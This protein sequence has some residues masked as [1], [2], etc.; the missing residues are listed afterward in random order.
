MTQ[1]RPSNR[2]RSA[3]GMSIAAAMLLSG[4]MSLGAARDDQRQTT[5]IHANVVDTRQGLIVRDLAVVVAD[6][7][8]N[9]VVPMSE[10]HSREGIKTDNSFWQHGSLLCSGGCT[11]RRISVVLYLRR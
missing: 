1:S 6:G 3:F 2:L 11:P 10:Y 7:H 8:I 4:A 9:A 5:Y